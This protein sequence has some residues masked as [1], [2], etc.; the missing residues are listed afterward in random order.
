MAAS[1]RFI[2][3]IFSALKLLA[4]LVINIRT[5]S[6]ER[7]ESVMHA[8]EN[9]MRTTIK[10]IETLVQHSHFTSWYKEIYCNAPSTL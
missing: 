4:E 5:L 2:G 10:K 3:V 1:P 7:I 8:N 6:T 9:N